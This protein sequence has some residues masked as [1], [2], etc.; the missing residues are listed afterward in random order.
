MDILVDPSNAT[1]VAVIS[2]VISIVRAVASFVAVA[3]LP[4]TGAFIVVAFMAPTVIVSAVI[5]PSITTVP[6]ALTLNIGTPEIS[7]TLNISPVKSS[8][9]E[10]N[11]PFSPITISS[12][13]ITSLFAI[14][15]YLFILYI[16]FH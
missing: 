2:P 14:F 6:F 13:L 3:A 10:N 9:T 16:N 7:D 1:A 11:S 5:V 12:C 4:V 15:I 8:V